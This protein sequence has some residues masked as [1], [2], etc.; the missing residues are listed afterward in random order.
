M[1][2]ENINQIQQEKKAKEDFISSQKK[3][4]TPNFQIEKD[5]KKPGIFS[6]IT[7]IFLLFLSIFISIGFIY[8]NFVKQE[9]TLSNNPQLISQTLSKFQLN[10]L[11]KILPN[12]KSISAKY[13]QPILSNALGIYDV[14]TGTPIY[15]QKADQKLEFASIT[16]IMT[17]INME[18]LINSSTAITMDPLGANITGSLAGIRSGEKIQFNDAL[19]AL[20]LPSGNDVALA[21]ADNYGYKDF[22]GK[23]NSI[24][25]DLQLT[26]TSFASPIGF[27]DPN[28]YSSVQDIF[29][30][31]RL[32]LNKDINKKV[33][34]TFDYTFTTDKSSYT[35][36]NTN[37][38]LNLPEVYG[39]KTGTDDKA[40]QCLV[41]Y[42]KIQNREYIAILLGS[43]NRFKEGQNIVQWLRAN[44]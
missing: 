2:P 16:K 30:M 41:L 25:H 34:R 15:E 7:S 10:S 39:L 3:I 18:S 23:M 17:V 35:V 11:I 21:I 27:D 4:T 8:L 26:N 22:V 28:N 14:N 42:I 20:M 32:F 5:Q 13:D 31:S 40:G 29:T 1:N 6:N 38:L 43:Q 12:T 33:V 24:A 9:I 19:Y 44:G 36:K 37:E